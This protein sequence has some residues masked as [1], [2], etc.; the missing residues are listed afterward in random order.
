M[1]LHVQNPLAD[2]ASTDPEDRTL[3][4]RARSGERAALEELVQRHQRWIY[5][6]AIRMLHHPQDA[7]DATQEIL[8]K[9]VTGLSSFEDRSSFRT[10][11]YRIVVNHVLNV[12]RG[13]VERKALNF[14][15]YGDDLDA[16]PDL[17]LPDPASGSPEASLLVAE[18][19][20]TCTS[21]MLLCLDR[22]Q[23]LTYILGEILGTSDTVG[24]ELLE[25]T[26]ENFRQR[27]SRARRDLHNFMNG[28]CGLVNPAN[29]CRCAKK[30]RGF[31]DAGYVDPENLVF[32]RHHVEHIRET[33]PTALETIKTL[34]DRCAAIYREHPFLKS[35]DLTAMLRRLL[36]SK[37]LR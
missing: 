5:N 10:W 28:K 32:A 11:L 7:E 9:A 30:T 2:G 20:I 1:I 18:A 29:P 3:V 23:R 17:D 36:A 4:L 19:M 12:K 6:I 27:L 13:R 37:E 33:A 34:D 15:A 31:I 26:R 24:A 8:L 22:E 14:K 16:T 21:G 25:I 35:P